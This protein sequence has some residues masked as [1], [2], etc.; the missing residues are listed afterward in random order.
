MAKIKAP[1]I[2]LLA[3]A[4]HHLRAMFIGFMAL[5]AGSIISLAFPAIIRELLKPQKFEWLY[6]H[7]YQ[8]AALLIVLLAV[9]GICFY[10]RGL[11][12]GSVGQKVVANIRTNLFNKIVSQPAAYFDKNS[13][14][15]LLSKLHTDTLILQD[16]LSI[17]LAVVTRY[18][19]QVLV[20]IICMIV[21]SPLLTFILVLVI[22]VLGLMTFF[23]FKN[24]EVCLWPS[25]LL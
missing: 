23:L 1:L 3:L 22:P 25:K 15:D 20:G 11:Y 18:S 16:A 7:P 5:A 13:S 24:L 12:F 6:S 19:I 2:K 21:L 4:K 14:G 17:K 8:I 10:I 9:Q